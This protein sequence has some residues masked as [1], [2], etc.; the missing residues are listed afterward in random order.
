MRTGSAP[1]EP[2]QLGSEVRHSGATVL[3]V[4]DRTGM[5]HPDRPRTERD[6]LTV[7]GIVLIG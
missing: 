1:L 7:S 2:I 4:T 6:A 3:P 5:S